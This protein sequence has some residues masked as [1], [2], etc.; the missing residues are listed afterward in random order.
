MIGFGVRRY[1]LTPEN[2]AWV[3][4]PHGTE[5]GAMPSVT[6]D[7]AKFS[8]AFPTGAVPSG[9]LVSRPTGQEKVVP[10]D[11]AGEDGSEKPLGFLWNS[12]T[13]EPGLAF[14]NAAYIHGFVNP[15]R[16]PIE[17]GKGALDAAA[18]TA[19]TNIIFD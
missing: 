5:P 11:P 6:L 9:V 1:E 18:R 14:S 3:R 16:L 10:Y 2:R 7:V 8:A 12:V 15:D 19:L 13:I 17:S 4:G